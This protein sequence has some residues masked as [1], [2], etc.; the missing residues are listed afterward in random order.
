MNK[1]LT[2]PETK[3]W[4]DDKTIELIQRKA[5]KER[6]CKTLSYCECA[7]PNCDCI[8][9]YTSSV[10][11]AELLSVLREYADPENWTYLHEDPACYIGIEPAITAVTKYDIHIN[12]VISRIRSK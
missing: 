9:D 10:I 4:I 12:N 1:Y 5:T 6:E 3:R 11:I 8:E 2:P 7:Y